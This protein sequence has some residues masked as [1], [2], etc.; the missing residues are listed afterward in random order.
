MNNRDYLLKMQ[1]TIIDKNR[2]INIINNYD[3]L[4]V[5]AQNPYSGLTK[6]GIIFLDDCDY[7]SESL[8]NQLAK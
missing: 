3:L 4:I 7:N 8:Y 2:F 5:S 1:G 6:E